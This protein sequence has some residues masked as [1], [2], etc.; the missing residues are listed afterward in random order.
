MNDTAAASA[1]ATT[2]ALLKDYLI[3][4]KPRGFFVGGECS[5]AFPSFAAKPQTSPLML[6]FT[7]KRESPLR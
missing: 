6:S 1:P 5:G 3:L 4:T 2:G 7:I